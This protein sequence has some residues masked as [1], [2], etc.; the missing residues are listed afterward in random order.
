[1]TTAHGLHDTRRAGVGIKRA[2]LSTLA[3]TNTIKN[4]CAA[5]RSPRPI[6]VQ[7]KARHGGSVAGRIPSIRRRISTNRILG[8]AVSAIWKVM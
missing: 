8:M 2:N 1:M 4:S 3:K 7:I 5:C 6:A